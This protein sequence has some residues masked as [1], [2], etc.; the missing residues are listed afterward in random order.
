MR[1]S[2]I[3]GAAVR[4]G[5]LEVR[6]QR[7]GKFRTAVAAQSYKASPAGRFTFSYTASSGMAQRHPT[8][9]ARD[10]LGHPVADRLAAY[11]FTTFSTS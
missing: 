3:F 5:P 11:T 7:N 2:D 4:D 9:K 6:R 8:I 10:S 1:L